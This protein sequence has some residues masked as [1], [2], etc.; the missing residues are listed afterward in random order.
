MA[1]LEPTALAM[2]VLTAL[3]MQK[4]DFGDAKRG[5]LRL[6]PTSTPPTPGMAIMVPTLLTTLELDMLP[7]ASEGR[8]LDLLLA[9]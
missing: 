6:S 2:L 1:M 3:T 5:L 7:T 9:P 8:R 4:L